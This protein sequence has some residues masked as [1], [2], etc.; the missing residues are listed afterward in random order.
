MLLCSSAS[1]SVRVS[2]RVSVCFLSQKWSIEIGVSLSSTQFGEIG[3]L[4]PGSG[5]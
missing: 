3:S 1:V 5:L 4:N 2:V